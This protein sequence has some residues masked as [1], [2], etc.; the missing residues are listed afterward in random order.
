ML[1]QVA[2]GSA[3]MVVTTV[4]HAGCTTAAL[5]ALRFSHADRR[6]SASRWAEAFLTA[7]LVL[8]MCFAS[9]FEAC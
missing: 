8:M 4:I 2:L 5:W 1:Q 3:L 6:V 9:L 7:A